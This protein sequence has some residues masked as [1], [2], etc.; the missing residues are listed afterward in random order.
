MGSAMS[1]VLKFMANDDPHCESTLVPRMAPP[2][3]L[4]KNAIVLPWEWRKKHPLM[5]S[6]SRKGLPPDLVLV[7][8]VE[9]PCE[10][11]YVPRPSILLC[12]EILCIVGI[13]SKSC[14]TVLPS[15]M[16]S[17]MPSLMPS[18]SP[19]LFPRKLPSVAPSVAH[20]EMPSEGPARVP[21]IQP[22]EILSEIPSIKPSN[23]PG[24]EASDSP[25]G[26]PSMAPSVFPTVI[27]SVF[28]CNESSVPS[29]EVLSE[30]PSVRP[31]KWPS[32]IPIV[33]PVSNP[34]GIQIVLVCGDPTICPTSNSIQNSIRNSNSITNNE[35]NVNIRGSPSEIPCEV[36]TNI[37]SGDSIEYPAA[38][39][40]AKCDEG[41]RDELNATLSAV[42]SICPTPKAIINP[43]VPINPIVVH[44]A[45]CN[46]QHVPTY[47]P[48]S[49]NS[50][51][52]YSSVK[53][54]R[55]LHWYHLFED[56]VSWK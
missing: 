14:P 48:S 19:S 10:R 25:S 17:A 15:M 38:G 1:N 33:M 55:C 30:V 12:G 5:A 22:S 53:S 41:L 20:C 45:N 56:Y 11:L 49:I 29:G 43:K 21:S 32:I 13:V 50:Q 16:T 24:G 52:N 8:E 28:F 7:V 46:A 35:H 42:P 40:A 3:L 47:I 23:K 27:A 26:A 9:E 37:P 44:D 4:W 31:S 6:Y 2:S 51:I 18:L 36:P 54:R 39:Q 34:S